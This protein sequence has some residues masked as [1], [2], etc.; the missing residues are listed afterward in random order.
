M[1]GRR[2]AGRERRARIR[3]RGTTAEKNHRRRRRLRP[4]RPEHVFANH[5]FL[6]FGVRDKLPS[7]RPAPAPLARLLSSTPP[8]PPPLTIIRARR[9]VYKQQRVRYL[10]ALLNRAERV[11]NTIASL[12]PDLPPADARGRVATLRVR[13]A[14]APGTA[15]IKTRACAAAARP[16]RFG[17]ARRGPVIIEKLPRGVA[18]YGPLRGARA[19][20]NNR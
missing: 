5:A 15:F 20:K 14:R 9:P 6:R 3:A 19:C 7:G 10:R 13:C 17:H 18:A 16:V 4:F 11:H 2:G 8:P 1:T 12:L